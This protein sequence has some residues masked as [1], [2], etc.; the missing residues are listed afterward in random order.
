MM[1]SSVLRELL[2]PHSLPADFHNTYGINDA[3]RRVH[4]ESAFRHQLANKS[5]CLGASNCR[6]HSNP[7][8][9]VGI[10]ER[11]PRM[12]GQ[13]GT[14]IFRVSTAVIPCFELRAPV[15]Q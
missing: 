1:S 12:P 10:V 11:L 2:V 15:Y 6:L 7:D 13:L 9:T 14:Y 4:R 3:I 5:G 8:K